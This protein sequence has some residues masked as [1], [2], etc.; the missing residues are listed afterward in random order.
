MDQQT[1]LRLAK[2][3]LGT[4]YPKLAEEIGVGA[5]TLEKWTLASRSGDARTMPLIARKFIARLLEDHKRA[6]IMAGDRGSAEVVDALVA[7]VSADKLHEVLRTFDAL[8]RS[9]NA[10]ASMSAPRNKPRFFKAASDKNR[11][12]RKEEIRNARRIAQKSAGAR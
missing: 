9:A 11:W 12:E 4:T 2:R 5:R 8:Q 1:F 6:R 3:E 7:Q 10:L